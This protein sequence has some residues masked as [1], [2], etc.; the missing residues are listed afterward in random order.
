MASWL[1]VA[2]LIASPGAAFAQSAVEGQYSNPPTDQYSNGGVQQTPRQAP[3]GPG[4]PVNPGSSASPAPSPSQTAS[5]APSPSQTDPSQVPV[6]PSDPA[7]HEPAPQPPE[8][9]EQALAGTLTDLNTISRSLPA[10]SQNTAPPG[11]AQDPNASLPEPAAPASLVLGGT[12]TI[13]VP[14][15]SDPTAVVGGAS[16]GQ[17]SVA[18]INPFS[19]ITSAASVGDACSEPV[20]SPGTMVLGGSPNSLCGTE[21]Q[22]GQG[23]TCGFYDRFGVLQGS[24]PT[25]PS[26]TTIGSAVPTTESGAPD[27]AFGPDAILPNI[28]RPMG[29]TATASPSCSIIVADCGDA[30]GDGSIVSDINPGTNDADPEDRDRDG[31]DTYDS[32]PSDPNEQ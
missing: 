20:S 12:G 18:V 11:T 8:T 28:V 16:S 2:L 10:L 26:S 21:M 4:A 24:C 14:V 31:S 23:N 17:P 13:A 30:D 27:P 29:T 6:G 3:G 22:D 7:H 19:A 25:A 1:V 5:P 15:T 9:F 32:D